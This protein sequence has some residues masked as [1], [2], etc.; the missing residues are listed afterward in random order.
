[1]LTSLLMSMML[2]F[3]FVTIELPMLPD[4][5]LLMVTATLRTLLVVTSWIN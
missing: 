3:L 1:M 4:A 5:A 2:Y